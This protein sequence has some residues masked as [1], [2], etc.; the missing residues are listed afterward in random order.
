MGLD[1]MLYKRDKNNED[2]DSR[3]EICYWRKA[4]AILNWF[5]HNLESV[6]NQSVEEYDG[7]F[8]REGVQNCVYYVVTEEEYKKLIDA[9]EKVLENKTEIPADLMPTQGFFFGTYGIDEWFW[10][11]IDY[12]AKTLKEA[13]PD[14][15]WNND[16]VEFYIWY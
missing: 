14:I 9:C 12:T 1:M 8:P 16:I 11:S 7:K 13:L 4:N 3:E 15:D 10:E 5:D 2:K 6:K